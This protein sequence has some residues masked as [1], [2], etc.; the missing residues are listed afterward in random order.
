M[1]L[2]YLIS[3]CLM[4]YSNLNAAEIEFSL[5]TPRGNIVLEFYSNNDVIVKVFEENELGELFFDISYLYK[6]ASNDDGVYAIY[7]RGILID[8]LTISKENGIV[9]ASSWEGDIYYMVME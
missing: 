8:I 4:M 7:D 2:I 5:T 1:K 6:Y 9:V 3:C